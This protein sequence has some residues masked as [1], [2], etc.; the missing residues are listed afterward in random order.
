MV[1]IVI[2]P[3]SDCFMP[4]L[5]SAQLVSYLRAH[6]LPATL[7][8]LSAELQQLLLGQAEHLTPVLSTLIC[9]QNTPVQQYEAMTNYLFSL[10]K[11]GE[12][13]YRLTY[14]DFSS[15]WDWRKPDGEDELFSIHADLCEF[16]C[17]L[18]SFQQ[19]ACADLVG[20]SI[21]Y[22]SQ[23]IPSLL[24]AGLIK[25]K[26][27][28][29]QILFGGSFFY[30]YTEEF[31]KILYSIDLVDALIVGPGEEILLSIA[32][33][34][35]ERTVESE[36]FSIQKI[37][38]HYLLTLL[39]D[40]TGV[41][42]YAPDFSDLAFD[43]YLSR[44]KAFPYMIRNQCYYGK[45]KFCNGDRDCGTILNK[46]VKKAFQNMNTIAQ[47]TGCKHAYIVDA[48]LSPSDLKKIAEMHGEVGLTWIA[49]GRFERVLDDVQLLENLYQSGCRMLRFGLESGSQRVLNL[50][51]KGINLEV[52]SRTLQKLHQV[53]ILSHVYLMFGY[54]GETAENRKETLQFLEEN[55]AYIDSYSI[56]IFQPIPQT[57]AYQELLDYMR[58]ENGIRGG[59]E[60]EQMISVLYPSEKEYQS[61]LED[62]EQVQKLLHF[63]AHTNG[64]Y[65][66]A[67]IFSR[68][69]VKESS[70]R[71]NPR[72]LFE[73]EQP[74]S[75]IHLE[76][77]LWLQYCGPAQSTLHRGSI[78]DMCRCTQIHIEIP[79]WLWQ[80]ITQPSGQVDFSVLTQEQRDL[81][82]EFMAEVSQYTVFCDPQ[83]S[84]Q[85]HRHFVVQSNKDQNFGDMSIQ[86]S[87][88][89]KDKGD[90]PDEHQP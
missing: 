60:Y 8:D 49:N 34:G 67:N 21:S 56:S 75:S 42:T 41:V 70:N 38:E 78:W 3:V 23:L 82:Q 86:F 79:D 28:A 59:S 15:H 45:C 76:K 51:N 53:G 55:R 17:A 90:G 37:G 4:T 71:V 5:G 11:G 80:A 9:N 27:P 25:R 81:V 32:K 12:A 65:Y 6:Q 84:A 14:D 30:N 66:S 61:L 48:A 43:R 87:P 36:E 85:A 64:E 31:T 16:L 33:I 26:H 68:N 10:C 63:Y 1:N 58:P 74:F 62:V 47:R 22:E 88:R 18:P 39:A 46:E 40:Q 13:R 2:P 35:L 77:E 89:T 72:M 7:Y 83:I 19:L 29:V 24:I 44:V 57:Q 54:W 73:H 52:A 50:M 69:P 20:F